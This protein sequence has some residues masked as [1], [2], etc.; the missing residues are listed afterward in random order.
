MTD[1]VALRCV[2]GG[3]D[4]NQHV[5]FRLGTS[6]EKGPPICG[7]VKWG[8]NAALKMR[9]SDLMRLNSQIRIDRVMRSAE[10]CAE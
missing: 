6:M 8:G 9:L 5:A 3:I 1:A 10:K 7:R 4:P 2:D